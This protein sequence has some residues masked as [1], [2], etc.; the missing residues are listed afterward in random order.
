MAE[1]NA[2]N[3]GKYHI[4]KFDFIYVCVDVGIYIWF[5]CALSHMYD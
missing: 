2:C 4:I 5:V 3:K 1:H